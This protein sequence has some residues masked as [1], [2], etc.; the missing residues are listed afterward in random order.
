ML[1]DQEWGVLGRDILNLV[2]LP[3]DGL[4]LICSEQHGSR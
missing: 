4:N 2:G 3:L 1:T